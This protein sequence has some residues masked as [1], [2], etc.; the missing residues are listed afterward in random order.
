M[1]SFVNSCYVVVLYIAFVND[2]WFHN[3]CWP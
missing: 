2:Q 3:A 1:I